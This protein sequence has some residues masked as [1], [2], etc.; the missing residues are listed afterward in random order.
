MPPYIVDF[1]SDAARLV[2]EL[3]GSQHCE[4]ADAQRTL[5]LEAQGVMVLRFW[6]DQVLRQAVPVLEEIYRVAHERVALFRGD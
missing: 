4:E 2:I 3:D 6:N 5:S 1:Y